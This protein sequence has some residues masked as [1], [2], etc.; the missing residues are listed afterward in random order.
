MPITPRLVGLLALT[1]LA[2]AAAFIVFNSEWLVAV[3]L[4]NIL[5]ITGSIAIAMSPHEHDEEHANG[6]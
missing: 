6:V 4:V 2:P 1:A 5:I 3:S